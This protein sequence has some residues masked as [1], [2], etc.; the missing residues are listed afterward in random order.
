LP[1]STTD[2]EGGKVKY[3]YSG[4]NVSEARAVAKP[5]SSLSDLVVTATYPSSGVALWKPATVTDAN[6]N[7]TSYT[8]DTTHG[9]VLSEVQPAVGG[10]SPAKKYG[11]TQRNA[12]LKNSGGTYT[13]AASGIYLLTEERTCRTSALNLGTGACGAGTSD[14]IITEYDYGPNSGPNNL[15]LRGM[16]VTAYD[17]ATSSIISLRTCYGYDAQGNRIFTTTPR[18]GLTVCA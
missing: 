15:L 16:I 18:A 2:A 14:L 5:G 1:Q 6:G 3:T 13:V 10:V 4:M 7:T 17:G 11:Y 12:W 9:G 8:Y